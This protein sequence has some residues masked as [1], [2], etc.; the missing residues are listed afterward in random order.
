MAI[1]NNKHQGSSSLNEEVGVLKRREIEAEVLG[2]LLRKIEQQLGRTKTR[3]LLQETIIDIAKQQGAELASRSGNPTL[4]SFASLKEPWIRG[5]A[6]EIDI[7]D[8]SETEYS[9]N[10]TRCRYAEMYKKLGLE[11]LGSLLSCARD[12]N[13]ATGFNKRIKLR[14]TQTIMDGASHCDFRYTIKN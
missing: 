10:V 1:N 13:M 14:R 4:G 2:P 9:F 11:D 6:L 12:F 8:K 7:L 3:A 5:G